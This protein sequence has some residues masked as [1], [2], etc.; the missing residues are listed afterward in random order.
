MRLF[1]K[2]E[3]MK[4]PRHSNVAGPPDFVATRDDDLVER[5][6]VVRGKLF[7]LGLLPDH[8][9]YPPQKRSI[10]QQKELA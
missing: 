3:G 8:V 5:A 7:E 1:L 6:L 2:I 4:L 9:L 10:S